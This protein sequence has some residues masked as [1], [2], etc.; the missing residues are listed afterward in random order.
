MAEHD[1][2]N[3]ISFRLEGASRDEGLVRFADFAVFIEGTLLTLKA[4]ERGATSK[5]QARVE[6]RVTQLEVGSAVLAIE[7]VTNAENHHLGAIVTT[8][9]AQALSAVRDGVA[10]A[11]GLEPAVRDAMKKMLAPLNRG[12]RSI[13]ANFGGTQ[14]S[15]AGRADDALAITKPE[16]QTS[17]VGSFSGSIDAL[18]VHGDHFFYLYPVVGPTRVK[19]VFDSSLLGKVRDAVKCMT[20]VKGLVEYDDGNPFPQR[21][22]V[23]EIQ[24]HPAVAELPTMR[25]LWGKYPSLTG[26]VDPIAYLEE[27]RDG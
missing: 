22:F 26:D 7:P 13:T 15:I 6:Y 14:I 27:I 17:A 2:T 24:T 4:I 5:K 10:D 20:T 19:C 11:A 16:Y 12:V 25:S 21:I 23:E 18:N 1:Q 3:A 8:R 9:F